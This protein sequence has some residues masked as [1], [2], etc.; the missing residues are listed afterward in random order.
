MNSVRKRIGHTGLA[1]STGVQV[2]CICCVDIRSRA[3][4]GRERLAVLTLERRL[5]G[6][7]YRKRYPES[8]RH[9]NAKRANDYR[10]NAK[11]SVFVHCS[12]DRENER[13]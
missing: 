8:E 1:R 13:H 3:A 4:R 9:Q 7:Q 10:R 5:S 6:K 12:A 11:A 2:V